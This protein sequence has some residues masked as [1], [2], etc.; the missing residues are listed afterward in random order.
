MFAV[1]N[2]VKEMVALEEKKRRIKK[3]NWLR[4]WIVRRKN[5]GAS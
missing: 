2:V 1:S 4:E 5:L 3:K